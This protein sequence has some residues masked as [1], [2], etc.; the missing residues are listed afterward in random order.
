MLNG[1]WDVIVAPSGSCTGSIRTQHAMVAREQDDEGLASKAEL[2]A[3]KTFDLPELIVDVLGQTD[4]GAYSPH[5]VTYHDVPLPS[6]S[7]RRR[8][9]L[10][11]LQVD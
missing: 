6:G 7:T 11:L 5:R 4:V 2:I 8:Q 3:E 9:P 1:E 10:Q